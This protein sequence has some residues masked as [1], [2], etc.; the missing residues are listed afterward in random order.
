MLASHLKDKT[1]L[2]K[3]EF[4]GIDYLPETKYIYEKF[5][6]K[7]SEIGVNMRRNMGKMRE[8]IDMQNI[9]TKDVFTVYHKISSLFGTCVCDMS[10]GIESDKQVEYSTA[11]LSKT[12]IYRIRYSGRYDNLHII[13]YKAISHIRMLKLK[14][15]SPYFEVYINNPED[16]KPEELVTDICISVE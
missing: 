14:M 11:M 9:K 3:I 2:Y 5:S 6:G 7:I 16:T 1:N 4:L 8:F 13:W 15:K 12:K 10:I